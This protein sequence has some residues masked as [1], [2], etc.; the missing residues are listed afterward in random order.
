ME[1]LDLTGEVFGRLKVINEAPYYISSSG[2]KLRLWNCVCE[3]GRETQVLQSNLRSGGSKSCGCLT[4]ETA[5]RLNTKHGL[6]YF[7]PHSLWLMMKNR[8]D[9]EKSNCWD[10]Y[11]GR[12][13]TYCEEW[14]IFENFWTDMQDGYDDSLTLDRI[15]PDGNYCKENCRWISAG[16]Q[17][18]NKGKAKN[19]KSGVVGVFKKIN[20]QGDKETHFWVAGWRSLKG[21][22]KSKAFSISKYGD[23]EA[24]ELACMWREKV[25]LELNAEGAGYTEFH[26]K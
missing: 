15:N 1:K 5:A 11:G 8:C 24:F 14:A 26:G 19:N 10:R 16:L 4:A 17:A 21:E 22:V 13:I 25:I 12:G 7:R 23:K 18:R 6:G 9:S 2:R 20:R 3:C